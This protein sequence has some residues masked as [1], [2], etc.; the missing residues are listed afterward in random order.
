MNIQ[1]YITKYGTDGTTLMVQDILTKLSTSLVMQPPLETTRL[2]NQVERTERM[3]ND[4]QEALRVERMQND[5][6]H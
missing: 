4:L 1:E 6:K 5:L 2:K 3:M